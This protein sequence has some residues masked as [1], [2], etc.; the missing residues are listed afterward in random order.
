MSSSFLPCDK[1]RD[2]EETKQPNIDYFQIFGWRF[3]NVGLPVNVNRQADDFLLLKGKDWRTHCG[4]AFQYKDGCWEEQESL[5][6]PSLDFLTAAE[7][8]FIALSSA[9]NLPWS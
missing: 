5:V 3:N 4:K 6:M 9:E 2:C 8:L 7:G 1:L